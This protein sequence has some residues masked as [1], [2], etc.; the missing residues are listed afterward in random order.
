MTRVALPG[1]P[2]T[3]VQ[4]YRDRLT[5]AGLDPVDLSPEDVERLASCRALLIPGGPD[6]DPT[7]YGAVRGPYTQAPV[8]ERDE[9]ELALLGEALVR[10]IPVLAI[11]RGHQLL[12]VAFGGGLVQHIESGHHEA[13]ETAGK[14]VSQH[15]A[16]TIVPDNRLGEIFE[17]PCLKVNSRHHQAVTPEIVGAGLRATAWSDDGFVEGLES[18]AHAW[19]VGV[20]WH[21]ERLEFQ[22]AGF[23]ET[24]LRLFAAFAKQVTGK[25]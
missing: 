18:D 23:A 2:A 8:P 5:E 15:H 10:D 25:R 3:N 17:G 24:S 9:F 19:V 16:V 1:W 13:R 12:N 22:L 11:C 21:P 14:L 4:A 7:R 20:Q 6:V